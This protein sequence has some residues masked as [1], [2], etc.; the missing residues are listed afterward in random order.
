M[1]H[2]LHK[3]LMNCHFKLVTW[4][5]DRMLSHKKSHPKSQI[6]FKKSS[7]KIYRNVK[8]CIPSGWTQSGDKAPQFVHTAKSEVDHMVTITYGMCISKL[9][10]LSGGESATPTGL[11]VPLNFQDL[12]VCRK[13]ST[14]SAQVT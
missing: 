2:H 13:S 7:L 10:E 3:G 9:V 1:S 14:N 6:I 4:F 12:Q 8:W 11:W 5:L